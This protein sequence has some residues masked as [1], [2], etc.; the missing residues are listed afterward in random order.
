MGLLLLVL[1]AATGACS[2]AGPGKA[3]DPSVPQTVDGG[4]SLVF[5]QSSGNGYAISELN[6]RTENGDVGSVDFSAAGVDP[7]DLASAL[8]VPRTVVALGAV[9][10]D[11]FVASAVY[12][13]LPAVAAAADDSFYVGRVQADGDV[14][15]AVNVGEETLLGRLDLSELT[16]RLLDTVWLSALVLGGNAVAAGSLVGPLDGRVL[17]TSTVFL[18]VPDDTTCKTTV[19][20]CPDGA[21]A[22]YVRDASRCLV[23]SGCTTP[24][25]CPEYVPLCDPGYQLA[26]WPSAGGCASFACDPTFDPAP[27][28]Y[29]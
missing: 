21:I 4:A 11:T 1:A 17:D 15:S 19:P 13:T 6:A 2:A 22:M 25:R 18:R 16:P 28:V 9:R 23:A 8:A 26:Q 29:R 3:G 7:R 20:A 12:R 10:G 24:T 5:V 27:T 14:A